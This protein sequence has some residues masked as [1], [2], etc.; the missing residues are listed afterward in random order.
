MTAADLYHELMEHG[1]SL[2]MANGGLAIAPASQLTDALRSEIRQHKA[3]IIFLL[4]SNDHHPTATPSDRYR[5]LVQC[6]QCEH[7]T[8]T[9][10]CRM[11]TG[12]KPMPEAKRACSQHQPLQETRQ[13]VAMQPYSPD[14]LNA[15]M[16][17]QED[18]LLN[19]LVQC[20]DCRAS[21]RRWCADGFAVGS[22]YDALL[23]CF[24]DAGDR[25]HAF[26]SRV[27]RKRLEGCK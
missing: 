13:P 5:H 16:R 27:I 6:Q 14:E 24:E 21:D 9:G 22:A 20:P 4:A 3:E 11:K 26:V 10:H 2:S 18:Q 15:L 23:L 17:R 12:Y 8:F 7:L 19:H 1:F 25:H